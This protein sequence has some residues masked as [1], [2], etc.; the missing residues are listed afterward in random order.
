MGVFLRIDINLAAMIMLGIVCLI[1]CKRLDM[2]DQLN[3]VF[4]ISSILIILE[5]LFESATC[6]LNARPEP[7]AIPV[8]TILHICLFGAAPMLTYFWYLMLCHWIFPTEKICRRKLAVLLIPVA[9]NLIATLLSP[10]FG[11]IFY[12][13]NDNIYHRGPLFPISVIIIYS[14]FIYTFVLILRQR[15]KVVREEFVPLLIVGILPVFGGLM[16]SL[17]YGLLLMWSC[18][19]FSLVVV[20]IFLQQRMVHLDD[21]TGAWTRGTFEYCISQRAKQRRDDEF[22]LI[23]L[24]VDGL[25]KI[26]DEYG[27]L[28]GD[29][30]LKTFVQLIRG[31]LRKTDIIARTGGDEFLIILDCNSR[32]QINQTISRIETTLRQHNESSKKDYLL[33]CS[34]GAELFHSG[35][36]DIDQFMRHVDR[37]M[38]ENKRIKKEELR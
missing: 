14:Y 9:V 3:K 36:R 26:N 15:K 24:D 8:S 22:G 5:L 19:G 12:I 28:E 21:L 27:H 35:F 1:A 23:L 37:L 6:I 2:K 4:L 29:Y 10:L 33:D 32:E 11:L 13:D 16:Q 20:Y 7:W 18:A 38:Y 25:K 17:F 30:A 34:I 31:T